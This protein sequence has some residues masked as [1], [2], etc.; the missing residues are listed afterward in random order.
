MTWLGKILAFVV[1][2][3]AL[4]WMYFTVNV[5]VTRTN[6]K[7]EAD[8]YKK[9]YQEAIAARESEHRIHQ[10]S[11]SAYAQ[12]VTAANTTI[13]GQ[14]ATVATLTKA[15]TDAVASAKVLADAIAKH[16]ITAVELGANLKNALQTQD[17]LRGQ[18]DTLAAERIALKVQVE[19]AE[20]G[21]TQASNELKAALARWEESERKLEATTAQLK[22]MLAQGGG[23]G[24]LPG[25]GSGPPP[26]AEGTRGT[27][28]QV[29]PGSDLVVLS[30]GLDAGLQAGTVLDLMRVETGTYLG[31]V[32]ILPTGLE[33]KKSVG[34]FS[35]KDT[36]RPISRLRPD[37]LPKVG[38]HVGK[39]NTSRAS[40][41]R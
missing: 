14:N 19:A 35:P 2:I 3:L 9:A 18:V 17:I 33:P 34:T 26:A 22:E 27:V 7:N 21:R 39:V 11:D 15:N 23:G 25:G 6:W 4:V 41:N 29:Q 40:N 10:S 1:M 16:D 13:T 36:N 31:T 5:Y 37:E 28:T 32:T 38:D 24:R 12:K 30:L 20:G 8:K